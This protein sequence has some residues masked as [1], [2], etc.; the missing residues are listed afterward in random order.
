MRIN[1]IFYAFSLTDVKYT[2]LAVLFALR[3]NVE[4]KKVG[5]TITSEL[6]QIFSSE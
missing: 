2:R 1:S 3:K 5:G 4:Q 6:T